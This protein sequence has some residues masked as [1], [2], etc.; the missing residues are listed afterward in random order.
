MSTWHN[1]PNDTLWMFMSDV[2]ET[3]LMFMTGVMSGFIHPS[4]NKVLR[5]NQYHGQHQTAYAVLYE[6]TS[7]FLLLRLASWALV[8][9]LL[10][11]FPIRQPGPEQSK[12]MPVFVKMGRCTNAGF[13]VGEEVLL[14]QEWDITPSPCQRPLAIFWA[15][16][17]CQSWI[18]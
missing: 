1:L 6:Y 11:F 15:G 9:V 5:W 7:A 3:P 10:Q 4:S 2:I 8:F 18:L 12:A 13:R 16:E 17:M 14:G